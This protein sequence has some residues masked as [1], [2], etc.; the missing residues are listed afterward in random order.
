M[1]CV[2]ITAVLSKVQTYVVLFHF[3]TSEFCGYITTAK[4]NSFIQTVCNITTD[5]AFLIH[6]SI[7]ALVLDN[8]QQDNVR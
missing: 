6:A 2:S 3:I 8:L 5:V 7:N 1:T 4:M